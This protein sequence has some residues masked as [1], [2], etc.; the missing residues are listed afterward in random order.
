M[1]RTILFI[2]FCTS[3]SCRLEYSLFVGLEGL[4]FFGTVSK[5]F[6]N[7]AIFE[8]GNGLDVYR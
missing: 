1:L 5:K 7:K 3:C 4:E 2:F 6:V 8:N